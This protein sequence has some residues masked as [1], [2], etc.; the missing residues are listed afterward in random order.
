MEDFKSD[1]INFEPTLY[2][3]CTLHEL[4]FL[5]FMCFG[6]CSVIFITLF[7]IFFGKIL[8]G[9]ALA[10]P[11]SFLAIMIIATFLGNFKLNKPQGYYQQRIALW[12]EDLG[13]RKTEYVRRS[14][15]WS[16]RRELK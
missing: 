6:G 2:K 13:I 10:I 11:A 16:V 8:L 4:M 15:K 1:R 3:G 9:L 5:A 14:G 12:L 7:L